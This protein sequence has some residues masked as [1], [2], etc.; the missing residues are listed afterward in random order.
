VYFV[1]TQ[2]HQVQQISRQDM[3]SGPILWTEVP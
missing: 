1:D 2:N 3:V